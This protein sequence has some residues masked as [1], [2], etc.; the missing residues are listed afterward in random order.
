[1]PSTETE[2]ACQL[3]RDA[4]PADPNATIEDV[5]AGFERFAA[6][7]FVPGPDVTATDVDAG[8]RPA[9]W[10]RTPGV[11]EDRTVLYL[12]GGGYAIGSARAYGDLASRIGRAAGARVLA[13][14]YRL[15]PE[16]PFPAAVDDAVA[17]YRWLLVQGTHP[18]EIVIAGDSA[19]GGLTLATLVAL[20]DHGD[21]LP[22]AGVCESPWVDMEVTGASMDRKAAVDPLANREVMQQMADAYLGGADPRSPLAAPLHA[23]FAGLPSLLIQVGT[24]ETLLDDALRVAERA[25][26]AGVDITL[27]E[28]DGMP[29]VWQL[30]ASFLPEAND[31]IQSIGAFIRDKTG[32]LRS[33]T[34]SRVA[35]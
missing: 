32:R 13:P 3:L 1:M 30:F 19:G 22:A 4:A 29:H 5:R 33:G 21:P 27:Q 7:H 14:N 23:D 16:H 20:R 26:A 17:A 31:A 28:F 34:V 15:A 10:L 2:R 35:T 18:E 9:L 6:Q 8:G 11:S 24:R 12:H 25:Q